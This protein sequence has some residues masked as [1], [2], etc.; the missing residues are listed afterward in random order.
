MKEENKKIIILKRNR[1]EKELEKIFDTG[2]TIITAQSGYGKTTAVVEFLRRKNMV[3]TVYVSVMFGDDEEEW[4]WKKI[5]SAVKAVNKTLGNEMDSCGFPKNNFDID[6][7]IEAL[8]RNIKKE[9]VIVFD[10]FYYARKSIIKKL[11]ERLI[12]E[13]IPYFHIVFIT[14][15]V[16]PNK[17]IYYEFKDKCIVLEQKV[18]AFNKAEIQELFNINGFILSDEAVDEIYDYTFGWTLAVCLLAEGYN[19]KEHIRDNMSKCF[20]LMNSLLCKRIS[21]REK[22]ILLKL[23]LLDEFTIKEAVYVTEEEAEKIIKTLEHEN[24]C[25]YY[26]TDLHTYKFKTIFKIMLKVELEKSSI[27]EENVYGKWISWCIEN[28][29]YIKILEKVIF[30]EDYKNEDIK[31]KNIIYNSLKNFSFAINIKKYNEAYEDF[32]LLSFNNSILYRFHK[33]YGQ[34]QRVLNK[35]QK[36]IIDFIKFTNGL[37][38]GLEDLIMGEYLYLT[39]KIKEAEESINKALEKA[40]NNKQHT[41]YVYSYFLFMK[42]SWSSCDRTTLYI[43]IN[44]LMEYGENYNIK[45]IKLN[46]DLA[47]GY[48]YCLLGKKEKISEWIK[49]YSRN[50]YK[51][52]KNELEETFNVMGIVLLLEER[53]SELSILCRGIIEKYTKEKNIIGLIYAHIYNAAAAYKLH[54]QNNAIEA[55]FYAV[56]IAEKDNIIMPFI[57]LSA[58]TDELI[59]ITQN[60]TN[61]MKEIIENIPAHK[62]VCYEA[63]C[64]KSVARNHSMFE[65]TERESEIMELVSNGQTQNDIA[66]SLHVSINTVRYHLK[67]IYDKLEVNNKTLAIEKYKDIIS[68]V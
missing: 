59:G 21:E 41:I 35:A 38:Y 40:E 18:F 15:M 2:L 6:N 50:L 39:G 55:F 20:K 5:S 22:N 56:N 54:E 10:D 42:I 45:K 58:F 60:N 37:D 3:D 31:I 25:V 1:V 47:G 68:R 61:F 57:E 14:R 66:E 11:V 43:K 46:I 34:M 36:A 49:K 51:L 30:L 23:C 29:A 65:L 62:E 9:T 7:L 8:Y 32:E 33:K 67:N 64:E 27:S 48:I 24:L 12:F 28:K 52:D 19:S 26:D 17:Y 13:K 53:Y 4:I 16:L 44:K 63:A